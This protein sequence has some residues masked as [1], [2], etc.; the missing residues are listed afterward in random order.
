MS[1]IIDRRPNG[2]NKSTV[3]RQRFLDR[4]RR[5]IKDAVADAVTRRSITDME[6]GEK[7]SIPTRDISEPVF[8]HGQ[9]GE[10]EMVH[11]GN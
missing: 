10:R 9:G 7:V 8:H 3:N 11:P 5:Q 1:Y 4:Y 2:R 6:H